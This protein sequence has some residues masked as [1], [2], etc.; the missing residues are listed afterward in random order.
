MVCFL[1]C[2][3]ASKINKCFIKQ[4]INKCFYK[5]NEIIK[6]PLKNVS[7]EESVS[8]LHLNVSIEFWRCGAIQFFAS[9]EKKPSFLIHYISNINT[10]ALSF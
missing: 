8:P 9:S 2:H 10:L 6:F 7:W 5:A 4:K 1:Y 3:M